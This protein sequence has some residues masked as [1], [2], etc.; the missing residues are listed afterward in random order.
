[1]SGVIQG[2][3][4]GGVDIGGGGWVVVSPCGSPATMARCMSRRCR[5]GRGS[6]G[7]GARGGTVLGGEQELLAVTAQGEGGIDPGE[8]V[9]GA[10]QAL[11]AGGAA[12]LA[13]V[14][15][16]HDGEVVGAL[17][18]AQ[19][20]EDGGDVAGLVLV[21]AVESHE[22]V[23]QE[24]ARG[25]AADGL[26]E[27]ALVAGQ[28]EPHAGRGDDADGEGGEVEAAVAAEARRR[29]LTTGAVSSAM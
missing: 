27:A 2:V 16:D 20:A 4:D 21:D 24:Q 9:S 1:M 3:E 29:C 6:T 8:E 10:A 14:V 23:E 17:Q 26:V 12:V 5:R 13:G 15:D 11:A 25:M 18:L 22:G 28:I 19:V 7:S